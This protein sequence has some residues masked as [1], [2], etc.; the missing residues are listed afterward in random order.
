V[1]NLA[2]SNFTASLFLPNVCENV[3]LLITNYI[4]RGVSYNLPILVYLL[5]TKKKMF[6]ISIFFHYHS[7]YYYYESFSLILA[8]SI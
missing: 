8:I 6:W 5:A 4:F 2:G 1:F 7:S 3:V